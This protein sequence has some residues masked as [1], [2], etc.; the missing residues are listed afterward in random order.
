MPRL[1]KQSP[2]KTSLSF[3]A[4]LLALVCALALAGCGGGGGGGGGGAAVMPTPGGGGQQMPGGGSNSPDWPVNSD[5]VLSHLGSATSSSLTPEEVR[6][7]IRSYSGQDGAIGEKPIADEPTAVSICLVGGGIC[8]LD[9][10][11]YEAVATYRGIPLV[12]SMGKWTDSTGGYT[13]L[14]YGGLLEHGY[15]M[16]GE[17]INP[18]RTGYFAVTKFPRFDYGNLDDLRRAVLRTNARWEGV[19]VGRDTTES[20]SRGHVIQGDAE[21]TATLGNVVSQRQDLPV[22]SGTLEVAF[23]NIRDLDAGGSKPNME[24][25]ISG[26]MDSP[27]YQTE[28]G[29]LGYTDAERFMRLRIIGPNREEVVGEFHTQDMVGAFGGKRQ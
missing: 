18:H 25:R 3:A 14:V 29:P 23:T 11:Q 1:K 17:A 6:T 9:S 15:F 5:A 8:T 20:P 12:Q 4:R 13:D 26:S 27:L 21:I 22:Y 2:G 10:E 19:M 16:A 7:R 28:Y 24:W